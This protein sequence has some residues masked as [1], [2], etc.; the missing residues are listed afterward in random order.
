MVKNDQK[1]KKMGIMAVHNAH[2]QGFRSGLKE[3]KNNLASEL[4]A[5]IGTI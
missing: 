4:I 2:N 3:Q 1:D 5:L